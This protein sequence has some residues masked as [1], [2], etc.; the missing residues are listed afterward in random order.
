MTSDLFVR[1]GGSGDR[2]LVLLHGLGGT[3]E[4][5]QGLTDRLPGEWNWVVPD[6]PG[7]GRSAGLPSYSFGGLTAEVAK[8]LSGD[9]VVLGHSLG[10]VLALTLA[11]GWFGPSVSAVCGLGIKVR[12]TPAELEKA[13]AVAAKPA[14]VFATREEAADRWLK[15]SGLVGL[16]PLEAVSAGVVQ[17]G[18][19]WKVALDQGAF[20]VGAPDLR[21]LL[22]A[23]RGP[24]V[25][26]AG[27]H[28]PMCPAEHLRELVPDP[29]VLP[30]LGHNAHVENPEALLPLLDRLR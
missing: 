24:V 15:V 28:D 9:V 7:H 18:D 22:A 10:G 30:G 3:G 16:V 27:E 29:V 20:G 12:W 14:R 4:V 21:G 25:L 17:D 1:R 23:A 26:A 5:W 19:G 13:A 6:L 11:S 8:S 2:T